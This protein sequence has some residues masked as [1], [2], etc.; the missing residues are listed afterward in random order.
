MKQEYIEHLRTVPLFAGIA[1]EDLQALTECFNPVVRSYQKGEIAVMAGEPLHG[2]GVVLSGEA[3]IVH[4]NAAGSKSLIAIAPQGSTF[5]EVAAFAGQTVWPSTV[6]ARKDSVLL[7]MPPDRFLGN[8]PRACGFHKVLIQNMLQILSE[9]AIRLNRK[10]EYLEIKGIR[11]KLCAYLLEQRKLSGTNTFILPMNKNELADYLNVSRPSMSRE[12][13][14]LR[15][16]GLLDFYLSS[17]RLLE[18]EA[19]RKIASE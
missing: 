5:G 2:V 17:V 11:Q 4:E 16:E 13:G 18:P 7:F 15:D 19:I 1:P 6:T 14:K 3:E 10:V 8:C 12:L 9:K